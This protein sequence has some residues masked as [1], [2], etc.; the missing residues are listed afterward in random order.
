VVRVSQHLFLHFFII[1]CQVMPC[2]A[3][4]VLSHYTGVWR[5]LQSELVL[6][7]S[8]SVSSWQCGFC[9]VCMIDAF[10]NA[11]VSARTS[12][13]CGWGVSTST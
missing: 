3:L 10:S 4:V 2:A 13:W 7:S 11:A 12:F 9:L 1:V 6:G 8:R 5:S